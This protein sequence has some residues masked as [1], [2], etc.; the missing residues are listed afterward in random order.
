MKAVKAKMFSLMPSSM[1]CTGAESAVTL[2]NEVEL[3]MKMN[4]VSRMVIMIKVVVVIFIIFLPT[5]KIIAQMSWYD[6]AKGRRKFRVFEEDDQPMQVLDSTF[7]DNDG[8]YNGS[9][10]RMRILKRRM[11][12]TRKLMIH[13]RSHLVSNLK[14]EK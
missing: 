13:S 9:S 11:L 10:F 2:R 3:R 6:R 14:P 4:S 1:K 12:S 7:Y 5:I 8:C